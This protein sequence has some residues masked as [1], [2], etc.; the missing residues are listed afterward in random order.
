[1]V[2]ATQK[3]RLKGF[4]VEQSPVEDSHLQFAN[5]PIIF[6]DAT[7]KEVFNLKAILRL[8]EMISGLNINYDKC[9]LIGMKMDAFF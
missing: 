6:C 4:K 9:E 3:A 1:M 2:K 7:A 8:F 5:N